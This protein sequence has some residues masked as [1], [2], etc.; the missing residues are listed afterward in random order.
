MVYSNRVVQTQRVADKLGYKAYYH[1]A[2]DKAAI[3]T[4]IVEGI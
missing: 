3:L 1:A 4:A 2:T